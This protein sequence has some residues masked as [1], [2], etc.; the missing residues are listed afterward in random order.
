MNRHRRLAVKVFLS[1]I[2][3][4]LAAPRAGAAVGRAECRALESKILKRPVRYCVFLPPSY[5]TDKARRFPAVYYLHGLGS[6]EQWMLNNGGWDVIEQ[7]RERGRIGEMVFV[8]P[9]GGRTFYVNSRDGK[10]MYEDFFI[11]E[12]VPAIESRYRA[13]GARAPRAIGGVSMGGYG[14]LRFAFRYPQM[15][16]AVAVHSPALFED[17]PASATDEFGRSL[18]AFGNPLDPAYW[19]NNT[20]LALARTAPGLMPLKIYFDCG[21]Q[22][23]FGFDVGTQKLHDILDRRKIPHEFHLYPGGHDWQFVADHIEASLG[24]LSRAVGASR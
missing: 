13:G 24:L 1:L 8:M 18:Q 15:F 12:F 4:C 22:D 20:P 10:Q 21:L 19:K 11:Q 6:N 9:D 17:L 5:D 16:V 2:A 3:C 7:L 23:D 14:A